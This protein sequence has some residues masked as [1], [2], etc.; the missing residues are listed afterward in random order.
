MNYKK[1]PCCGSKNSIRI[2]YGYP[3]HELFLEAQS[4]KVKLGGCCIVEGKP[5]YFCKD[6]KFEWNREQVIDAAYNKIKVLKTSVGGY[7][8]G[9]YDVEIDLSNCKITWNH[10]GGGDKEETFYKTFTESTAKKFTEQLKNINLLNWKAKYIEP[11]VC[12]GTQWSVEII[13]DGRSTKKR[14]D[15]KFP[16]EWDMFCKLIREITNKKFR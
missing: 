14:G 11:G 10:W 8:R 2:V 5:E 6:C 12:D 16:E 3:S 4:G 13:I 15:N 1:C 9:Y 7:F